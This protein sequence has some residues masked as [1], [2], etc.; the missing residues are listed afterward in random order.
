MGIIHSENSVAA[1]RFRRDYR[2]YETEPI[3]L[4]VNVSRHYLKMP[5]RSSGRLHRGMDLSGIV[6]QR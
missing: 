4:I 6:V 2:L 5:G 1:I 3:R